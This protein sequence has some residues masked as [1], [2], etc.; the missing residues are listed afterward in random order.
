MLKNDSGFLFFA[1]IASR[2]FS[3]VREAPFL[4]VTDIE[5]LKYRPVE[6][7]GEL[8]FHEEIVYFSRLACAKGLLN[9]VNHAILHSWPRKSSV[10]RNKKSA[11]AKRL[12]ANG[13]QCT[14][15]P[16]L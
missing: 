11:K 13:K 1:S 7:A 5:Y 4:T 2:G 8:N 9:G 12:T 14:S 3:A 6:P 16:T 10:E 15:C